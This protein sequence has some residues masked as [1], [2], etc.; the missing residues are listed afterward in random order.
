M[1]APRIPSEILRDS[2]L[3]QME[4]GGMTLE[5]LPSKSRAMLYRMENGKTVRIRT[6]NDPILIVVADSAGPGAGLNIEGTDHLLIVMPETPRTHGPVRTYFVPTDVAVAAVRKSHQEWLDSTPNTKGDN[7]TWNIW[8]E[9][10]GRPSGNFQNIW[11]EYVLPNSANTEEES[12]P[13]AN[14]SKNASDEKEAASGAVSK[15]QTV[16]DVI[17][18]ATQK[19]SKLTGVSKETIKIEVK[20]GG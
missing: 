8:F 15:Q 3:R 18:E 4:S 6:T 5:R 14:S 19:I 12:S 17:E 2:A 9:D 20:I 10:T 1:K 16:A 11:A 13:T 7:K